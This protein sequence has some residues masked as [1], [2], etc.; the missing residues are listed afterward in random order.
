MN[1]VLV[2]MMCSR[3]CTPQYAELYPTR[4]ACEQNIKNHSTWTNR[5]DY[6]I[7]VATK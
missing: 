1:W 7:P 6:C 2:V 5:G 3:Y 4:A